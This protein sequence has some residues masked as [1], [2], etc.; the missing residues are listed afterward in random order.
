MTKGPD[1]N[2]TLQTEGPDTVRARHDRAHQQLRK[3]RE[4]ANGKDKTGDEPLWL[5]DEILPA[6]PALAVVFGAA[7]VRKTF[8]V[9]DAQPSRR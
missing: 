6:G 5:L 8:L 2:D 3:S 9:A 7:K 4:K 1:I